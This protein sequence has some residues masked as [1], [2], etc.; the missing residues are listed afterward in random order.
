MVRRER[1]FTEAQQADLDAQEVMGSN[2]VARK[3]LQFS[4]NDVAT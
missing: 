2:R 3:A 1:I 4:V